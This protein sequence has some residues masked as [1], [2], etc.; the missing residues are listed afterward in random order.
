MGLYVTKVPLLEVFNIKL[1]CKVDVSNL[2]TYLNQTLI[3]ECYV[4]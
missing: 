2:I 4:V 3:F 1:R